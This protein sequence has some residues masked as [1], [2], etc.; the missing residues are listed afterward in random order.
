LAPPQIYQYFGL[1]NLNPDGRRQTKKYRP[2]VRLTDTLAPWLISWTAGDAPFAR[3]RDSPVISVRN[4]FKRRSKAL[5][6]P[7]LN[8]YSLR[9]KMATELAARRVSRDSIQRQIGHK[10]PDM[11]TTERYIKNDPRHLQDAKEAIEEYLTNLN[12]LTDRNLLCPD[13]FKILLTDQSHHNGQFSA[14][15]E[16]A[17]LYMD[18]EVVGGIGIE[19]MTPSMS[20]KCSP[21]ELTAPPA[22]RGSL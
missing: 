13:T 22:G 10:A 8:A 17:F 12:R 11:R 21:A 4:T 16:L 3:F 14:D 20:R 18:L 6:L 1:V 5:N 9:H 19:P 2:T 7:G 15:D